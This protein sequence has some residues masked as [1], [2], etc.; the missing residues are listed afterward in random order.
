MFWT[1]LFPVLLATLFNLAFSNLSSSDNFLKVNVAVVQNEELDQNPAF[2]EAI[3]GADDLFIVQ[4]TTRET[5][6]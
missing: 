6:A 4:Y 3:N 2:T 5:R 1:F